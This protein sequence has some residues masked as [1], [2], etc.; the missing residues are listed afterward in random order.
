MKSEICLNYF[1]I[2]LRDLRA[3]R[4]DNLFV[5]VVIGVNKQ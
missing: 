5:V 3:L 4:G 2:S 1:S